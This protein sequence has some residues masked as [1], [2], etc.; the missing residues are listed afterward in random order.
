[1]H[2]I[3]TCVALRLYSSWHCKNKYLGLAKW[4]LRVIR[5]KVTGKAVE[6]I[7]H[8]VMKPSTNPAHFWNEQQGAESFSAVRH[9]FGSRQWNCRISLQHRLRTWK[10]SFL[11]RREKYCIVWSYWGSACID[12]SE[13]MI[14]TK[15]LGHIMKYILMQSNNRKEV[16]LSLL[17]PHLCLQQDLCVSFS[18]LEK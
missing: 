10:N 2:F 5:Q 3:T 11:N 8:D 18:F 15:D 16:L 12:S 14:L 1:M 9:N 7:Y 4:G 17:T 13:D 6:N